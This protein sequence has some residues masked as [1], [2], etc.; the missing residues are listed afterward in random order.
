ME[1]EADLNIVRLIKMSLQIKILIISNKNYIRYK[2]G[3]R[4][5]DTK[6]NHL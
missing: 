1:F 6:H 2:K 3:Y 5:K 4:E